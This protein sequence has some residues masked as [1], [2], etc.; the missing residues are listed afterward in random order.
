VFK[1]NLA[2]FH[3]TTT[4]KK[5]YKKIHCKGYIPR[6]LF[7]GNAKRRNSPHFEG[8][9]ILKSPYLNKR[10]LEAVANRERDSKK[11][12]VCSLT[13]LANYGSFPLVDDHHQ[14]TYFTKLGRKTKSH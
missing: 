5:K 2:K 8:K 3:T 1:K 7:G 13:A 14:S 9:K 10:F 12:L 11:L 4:P 6:I